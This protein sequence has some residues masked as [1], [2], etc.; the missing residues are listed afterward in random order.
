MSPSD[1]LHDVVVIGSGFGGSINALR[2]A[3]AGKSVL[4][5]ERGRRYASDGFPRDVRDVENLFW[6]YPG[7]A[8]FRGLYDVRFFSGVA[9]VTASGVGGGSLVY[10]NIHIRPDPSVFADDRWPREINV[11]SLRPYYDR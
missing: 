9:T 5:V 4:V 6:G 8:R 7:R 1:E 3:Q 10:A 2:A 11:E